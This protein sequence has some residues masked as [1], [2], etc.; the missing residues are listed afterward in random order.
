MYKKLT[1]KSLAAFA[2]AM[3]FSFSL[4]AQILTDYVEGGTGGVAGEVI[5]TVTVG[6]AHL[7]IAE[8]DPYYNPSWAAATN[9]TVAATSTW[10]W[11]SALN[12]SSHSLSSLTANT[13]DNTIT[14]TAGATAGLDSIGVY[15]GSTLGNI[16]DG[17]TSYLK[18]QVI[19]A[20]SVDFYDDASNL[21]YS[22]YGQFSN[23]T[24]EVCE[25]DAQLLLNLAVAFTSTINGNPSYQLDY[26]LNVYTVNAAGT[27]TLEG[28]ETYETASNT[29]AT[30]IY[31]PNYDIYRP[32]SGDGYADDY[33][34]MTVS[35][36][37]VQTVYDYTLD[38]VSD[39]ISR[40][41]DYSS[42]GYTATK[43][44][45]SLFDTTAD[46]FVIV[47]NP[48]PVTGPIYHISNTWAK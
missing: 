23:D 46:R 40:K 41:A 24:L 2:V 10:T 19:D 34:C 30:A 1:M 16:C 6:T 8:P 18:I 28:T 26:E 37:K 33:G 27:A 35:G 32:T 44:V 14:F 36:S 22:S 13:A 45:W 4:S 38:G 42:G 47:V 3:F 17:D 11:F 48:A 5:D 29:Q 20:S 21:Y 25:G 9:T 39:R 43:S 7:Y 12:A 31:G 15:E